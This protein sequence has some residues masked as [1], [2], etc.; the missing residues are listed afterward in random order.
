MAESGIL[1]FDFFDE[2]VFANAETFRFAFVL[3]GTLFPGRSALEILV[4]ATAGANGPSAGP[5]ALAKVRMYQG[6]T[7]F[8]MNGTLVASTFFYDGFTRRIA[9]RWKVYV[10][11]PAGIDFFTISTEGFTNYNPMLGRIAVFV[12]G[13]D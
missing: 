9:F 13:V 5:T 1:L 8:S 11:T 12:R 2:T 4:S 10:P 6:G 3:D 7:P